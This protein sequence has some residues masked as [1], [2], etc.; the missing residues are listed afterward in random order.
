MSYKLTKYERETI[1]NFNEEEKT[2]SIYTCSEA[3]KKKLDGFCRK[4]PDLYKLE[5][6]DPPSKT[7]IF[8]K[9]LVSIR[10]PRILTKEQ[11]EELKERILKVRSKR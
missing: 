6:D 10:L 9:R 3:Y 11:K 1:I 2:A 7:Y 8:P 4:R 5:E